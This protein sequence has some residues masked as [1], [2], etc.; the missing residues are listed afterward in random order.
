M[1]DVL[2]VYRRPFDEERPQVRSDEASEPLVGE[3]AQ[4]IP[5]GPG[6][7]ERFEY[8]SVRHGAANPFVIPEPLAGWRHATVTGRR[9]ATDSAEVLRWR[10]ED[11]YMEADKVVLVMDDSSAHERAGRYDAF[12]PEPARRR[13]ARFEAHHAP[14]HGSRLNVAEVERSALARQCLD[15]RIEPTEELRKEREPRSEGRNDR[16]IGANGRF[17]TA[18]ARIELRRLDPAVQNSRSPSPRSIPSPGWAGARWNGCR[19][20]SGCGTRCT[21][22]PTSG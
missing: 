19:A 17:T 3:V 10:A 21:C 18:N 5:A 9:T 14:G 16:G 15:R 11:A 1:E 8:E 2:E 12:E 13:A 22:A 4:P 20:R 7:P 6:P